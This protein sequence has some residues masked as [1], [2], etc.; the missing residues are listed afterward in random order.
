MVT[1]IWSRPVAPIRRTG[2]GGEMTPRVTWEAGSI[3]RD[4]A[5]ARMPDHAAYVS[6]LR[7]M[8]MAAQ[9]VKVALGGRHRQGDD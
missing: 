3:D 4:G 1:C 6:M 9:K 5:W 7:Q 8:Q 2:S